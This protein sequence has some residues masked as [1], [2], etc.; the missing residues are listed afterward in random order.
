MN[1]THAAGD[2]IVA[3][4]KDSFERYAAEQYGF[5]Q[6]WAVLEEP[7][8][9]SAKAWS[10]YAEM[11]LLAA[12]LPE[13]Y[14]GIEA[15][16]RATGAVMETVGARLLMEPILASAL[17]G[18]GLIL[19]AASEAQQAA[20]LP[21]LAD[22]SL[23]LAFG[24]A[25]S[26]QAGTE[27]AVQS[28]CR[29]GRLCGRKI[30]LLHGDCADRI[31]VSALDAVGHPGLYMVDAAAPGVRR[32]VLSLLDG[33][34]AANLYF[35][36]APAERLGAAHTDHSGAISLALDEAAVALCSE[37]YGAI[38][39]L[40]ETT[41]AY[42][43]VRVQFGSPIGANQALQHRMVD[44]YVLQQEVRALT[45]SAQQALHLPERARARRV[46]G[47]RAYICGAARKIAAEAVQLHG[48]MGV[49]DELDVSHYYR[50]L[51]VI[52]NL[53]GNRDYH[54]ARFSGAAPSTH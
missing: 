12:R 46:S 33:R 17:L 38:R 52:G 48:G 10:D 32:E 1:M 29:G 39:V 11:G 13:A 23:K 45:L 31:V 21:G 53:F 37:A 44:M 36:H 43:K 3:L 2:D 50:R 6:R 25:E 26:I 18:T 4:L 19:N 49:T 8:R 47:A 20:L 51:M 27:I 34:G 7:V 5:K 42:L 9:Y 16:A 24:H 28:A 15:D 35:E 40:N 54:L 22:G 14:G 30:A 41:T